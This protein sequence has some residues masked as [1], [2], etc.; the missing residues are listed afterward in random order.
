MLPTVANHDDRMIEEARMLGLIPKVITQLA[1]AGG[2]VVGIRH[3]TEEPPY[4]VE[5]DADGLQIRRY[6][7]RIAAETVVTAGQLAARN[8]GFRRLAGY[9]F[10]SNHTAATLSA[11]APVAS[12]R[13]SDAGQKIAMT[14]PVEQRAGGSGEWVIQFFMP[15][16]KT[17]ELLPEPDDAAVKLV[18]VPEGTFAVRRFTGDRGPRAIKKQTAELMRGLAGS[19]FEPIGE[20]VTWFYDPPWTVPMLRRNEIAVEVRAAGLR[21]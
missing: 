15:A 5:H 11:T 6:A 8:I 19:G 12:Q 17:M 14:A 20:P 7:P 4:T 18:H 13:R 16:D 9:I 10:G 21:A 3:G 2:S 1:E